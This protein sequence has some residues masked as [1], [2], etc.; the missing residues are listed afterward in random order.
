MSRHHPR[1]HRQAL[2]LLALAAAGLCASCKPIQVEVTLIDEATR[3]EQEITGT[4]QDIG[5]SVELQPTP[6]ALGLPAKDPSK[7]GLAKF[8]LEQGVKDL[9][10]ALAALPD[11]KLPPT[12]SR[13]AIEARLRYNLFSTL[14]ALGQAGEAKQ[15]LA[16]A[17]RLAQQR[18]MQDLLWK[19]QIEEAALA[20]AGQR[21]ALMQK[22]SQTLFSTP[23][24]MLSD[25]PI[26]RALRAALQQ[27]IVA[28]TLAGKLGGQDDAE[29]AEAALNA[30]E[31]F[32]A[33]PLCIFMAQLGEPLGPGEAKQIYQ[34]VSGL[35]KQAIVLHS[36]LLR[37][38]PPAD[39]NAEQA[40]AA[41]AAKLDKVL[42]ALAE[43]AADA[44]S[45]RFGRFYYFQPVEAM[46]VQG[47]L[48]EEAVY[49]RYYLAGRKLHVWTM[50]VDGIT[51]RRVDVDAAFLDTIDRLSRDALDFSDADLPRLAAVLLN[52]IAQ[53]L[54]KAKRIYIVPGHRLLSLPWP[55][56][57]LGGA[58]LCA[59]APIA[60]APSGLSLVMANQVRN[61]FK[62]SVAFFPRETGDES[63]RNQVSRTFQRM[64]TTTEK[65][66]TPQNVSAVLRSND[67]AYVGPSYVLHFSRPWQSYFAFNGS[68]TLRRTRLRDLAAVDFTGQLFAMADVDGSTFRSAR[69]LE[70][71]ERTVDV[72]A[73]IGAPTVLLAL[74]ARGS[75]A[76][77]QLWNSFFDK[78]TKLPPGEALRQAQIEAAQAAP[79]DKGWTRLR[80]F[81]H[82]GMDQA[83]AEEFAEEQYGQ[84]VAERAQAIRAKDWPAVLRR[85]EQGIELIRF[86]PQRK[87]D[88]IAQEQT[89]TIAAFRGALFQAAVEHG[90]AW[91]R[92]AQATGDKA[93]FAEARYVLGLACSQ[94][95]GEYVADAVTNLRQAMQAYEELGDKAQV[96]ANMTELAKTYRNVGQY[97]RSLDTFRQGLALTRQVARRDKEAALYR[98]VG[99]IYLNDLNRYLDAE[100]SFKKAY[101]LAEEEEDDALMV[102]SQIDMGIARHKLGD[103]EVAE[104]RLKE[105]L[106]AATEMD[107][108]ELQGR[109]HQELANVAWYQARYSEALDHLKAAERLFKEAKLPR[110]LALALNTRGLVFWTLNDHEKALAAFEDA[111]KLAEQ[112]QALKRWDMR[113]DIASAYNNIG[114]IY[115]DRKQFDEAIGHFR[116]ALRTDEEREDVWGQAYSH[117]NLGMTYRRMRQFAPAQT[118]LALAVKLSRQIG[119]KTNLAKS[120]YSL[121]N[122]YADQGRFA[123]AQKAYQEAHDVAAAI[124]VREIEWRSLWGLGRMAS[125]NP[126]GKAYGLYKQAI[127][128]VEKMRAAIRVEEYRNGFV[129]NKL[130]L[131]Y[132]MVQ[133]LLDQ[134]KA[135]EAFEYSERSR[136]RS[137]I[138]LLGN[139]T[140]RVGNVSDQKLL[141][142]QRAMQRQI[143]DAEETYK[144]APAGQAKKDAKAALLK[145]RKDYEDLIVDIKAAN[146]QLS[147]FV[148]V[149]TIT[150]G[151][152]NKLLGDDVALVE[153]LVASNEIITWVL[154]GGKMTVTRTPI[155]AAAL[156]KDVLDLRKLIQGIEDLGELPKK[157]HRI[158]IAPIQKHIAGAKYVCIA[159]HGVLHYLPFGMLHDGDNYLIDRHAIFYTP[160]ASVLRFTMGKK[161]R[162]VGQKKQLRVLAIGNPDLG[163]PALALPFAEKEVNSIPWSFPKID[164]LTGKQAT[165]TALLKNI[166]NYD[167]IHIASHAKFDSINPLFSALL[168]APDSKSDGRLDYNDVFAVKLRAELI[169]LSACQ[170]G[171]G[172]VE[173][174]DE[175]IGLNRA[176]TYAGTQAIVSSLWRVSDVATGIMVKHFYRNYVTMNK[177]DSLRKAQ[178]LVKRYYPHPAYWAA[179][180]LTGEYR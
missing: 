44:D 121:G 112:E 47:E 123:D 63:L 59:R 140:I 84:I 77:T 4:Y 30:V 42:Q 180:T 133:L 179:F 51:Y 152:A 20:P 83:Q 120:L 150:V 126:S 38:D 124:F 110:L 32:A 137:F 171:L 50:N 105:A 168:L 149:D 66:V 122:V 9:R 146:P 43:K 67:V 109:A 144:A 145:L 91:A 135:G 68:A 139:H 86:L 153:Y 174:G 74:P 125:V 157:L 102:Q 162:P 57:P 131:Y 118:H 85:C 92:L 13:A 154:R 34:D 87:G 172:K 6:Q 7:L 134:G 106:D 33:L 72:L 69:D 56:L 23:L 94:A 96:L 141:D 21:P 65:K 70:P 11:Q 3:L 71:L 81:G 101:D 95:G 161:R 5:R 111:L 176:F 90:R 25:A 40:L 167:I 177:A 108:A 107:D 79:G 103:F 16:A 178:L 48:S 104:K 156:R 41:R 49:V 132:D 26:D 155:D 35:R 17:K 166:G 142:K 117:K 160:S 12:E 53:D 159:P 143:R 27:R 46:D 169:V 60:F 15:E 113:K 175:I 165:E 36:Q 100:R 28:D 129:A 130:D 98:Y 88:A 64:T 82:L 148:S 119:D 58:M 8:T 173:D 158:L 138:D 73:A 115:R 99:I 45:V 93:K 128:V 2:A 1:H 62:R 52:P 164:I 78:F 76:S 116:T 55:A 19:I 114:L 18:R 10:T 24:F 147:S 127:G 170:T 151:E 54:S 89:A 163:S 14:H 39:A 136:G 37:L 61:L 22:A 97:Q 75:K 29:R 31:T 80:I